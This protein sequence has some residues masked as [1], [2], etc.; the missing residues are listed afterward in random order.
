MFL[1]SIPLFFRVAN[2]GIE[3]GNR[4]NVE[5]WKGKF[6]QHRVL[7]KN[8]DKCGHVDWEAVDDSRFIYAL[9]WEYEVK[10]KEGDVDSI[11]HKRLKVLDKL[12]PDGPYP[13]YAIIY[14]FIILI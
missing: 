11:T 4:S 5:L 7:N 6:G 9:I 13:I 10:L 2:R 14:L 8:A 3:C 12:V 1:D